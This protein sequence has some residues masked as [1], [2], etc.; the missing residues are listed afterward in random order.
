RMLGIGT[1]TTL[2]HLPGGL[3]GASSH[4]LT[5]QISQAAA[6]ADAILIVDA[7]GDGGSADRVMTEHAA[8]RAARRLGRPLYGWRTDLPPRPA[9]GVVSLSADRSRQRSAVACHKMIS[10]DDPVRSQWLRRGEGGAWDGEEFLVVLG[11]D[12]LRGYA[13]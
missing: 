1:V 5:S 8:R 12:A 11:E 4:E 9:A 6:G 7:S 10:I 3:G 2:D 13:G